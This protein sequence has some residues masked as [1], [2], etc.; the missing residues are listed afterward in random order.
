[1]YIVSP[2]YTTLKTNNWFFNKET[3]NFFYSD[4]EIT[5]NKI[6]LNI[7]FKENIDYNKRLLILFNK[8]LNYLKELIPNPDS[9]H[10][11]HKININE[12]GKGNQIYLLDSIQVYKD[13]IEINWK[14]TISNKI[15]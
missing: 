10:I 5:L 1:M 2:F 6:Y 4:N 15:F 7:P 13:I 14:L 3:C 8:F 12:N 11:S 9:K